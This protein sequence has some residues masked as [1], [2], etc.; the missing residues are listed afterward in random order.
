MANPRAVPG[1]GWRLCPVLLNTPALWRPFDPRCHGLELLPDA[2]LPA[3][4][5]ALFPYGQ[6][7]VEV[8]RCRRFRNDAGVSEA[9]PD[10]TTPVQPSPVGS[11][12]PAGGSPD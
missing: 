8:R 10:A 9:P 6:G 1:L 3:S 4:G 2:A 7:S 12:A 11:T 5:H